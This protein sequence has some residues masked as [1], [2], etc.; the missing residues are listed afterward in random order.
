MRDSQLFDFE[1]LLEFLNLHSVNNQN[2]STSL[3]VR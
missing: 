1:G 3:R 2:P